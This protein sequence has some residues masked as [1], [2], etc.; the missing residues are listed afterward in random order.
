[1]KT[2][3][4]L[5]K[6]K[7]VQIKTA[8]IRFIGG[9]DQIT[10]PLS[11]PSGFARSVQNYECDVNGGYVRAVGYERFD[12]RTA[13]S[14]ATYTV[15]PCT[16]ITGGAVGETLTGAGGATGQIIAVTS[17]YFVLTKRNATAYVPSENL[18]VGAGTIAIATTAGTVSGAATVLL[19]AQYKNLAADVYR[20]DIAA[21]TGIGG[22]LGGVR[23][24]GVTYTFRNN[25]DTVH[26]DLW[27]STATGWEQVTL[28]NEVAFTLG[29]ATVPAE[30]TTLTQGSV[31]A[32]VK[33]VVATTA[34]SAWATNTAAGR[35]I[36]TNPAG[37][38][39]HFVSG[40]ATIG[41]INVTLTAAE[42][43]IVLLK[44][45]RYQFVVDNFAGGSETRRIYG[46]DGVNRGFEFD[47]T[48]FVPITTGMTSDIPTNVF[49]HKMHLF[50]SF[51]GSVQHAGPG[52]PYI[53]SVILGAAE[54][55]LGDTVTGFM[56]QPGSTSVGALVIFTRNLTTML[57]G[58]GVANWQ[59]IAYRKELG[60][61]QYT[62]QDT[63][64]T[65]F[66]DDKG[67]TTLDA[68][69]EFGN[70]VHNSVSE[71]IRPFINSQRLT[72][73]ASCVVGN[74]SQYR[75]F[76]SDGYAAYV[77]F[78]GP[79]II[80][81]M[82]VL[83]PD[84]VSWAYSSEESDGT[85]TIF[86]GSTDGMVYQMEKG[87]SFDGDAIEHLLYLA[88]DFLKSPRTTK[89]FYDAMVEVAG[90]GYNLL[91][92]NYEL[93]YH[94]M[95]IDQQSRAEEF[96]LGSWDDPSSTW[97]VGTWDG[98]TVSPAVFDMSGEAENISLYFGGS[99]DYEESFK[100]S[101]AVIHYSMRRQ[102]R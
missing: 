76:F 25:A 92:F 70:F 7:L 14:A 79:K 41:A 26:A 73:T 9:W 24:G 46:C 15:L 71:R 75:L 40:A 91:Y 85:E 55:G 52:T 101:G 1:M 16:S 2:F 32:T 64:R 45:G 35:L 3:L 54:L 80:G 44:N 42:T 86:F 61:Y 58:T 89:R 37:G 10:P 51:A 49:S 102:M 67:I 65:M 48:V 98:S 12:G 82:P 21:P 5:T 19:H 43:A 20:A 8:V 6:V 78:S 31:T 27:K 97:D 53:W 88:W 50:F 59:L 56:T 93:G 38:T 57:Y 100:L 22:N 87:T 84:P 90:V 72:V 99:S 96:A 69:Q 66:L 28:Y 23:F 17:T 83:F 34:S 39:G 74:K 18:N 81:I 36:V 29:G 13:P 30:G 95:N 77:T 68:A 33:R 94:D 60:A 11:M 63:G 47:G 4:Q 62:I